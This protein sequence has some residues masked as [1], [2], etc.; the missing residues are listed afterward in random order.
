MEVII[1]QNPLLV[2]GYC[3]MN[4]VLT[5]FIIMSLWGSVLPRPTPYLRLVQVR[6]SSL[7]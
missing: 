3:L 7:G 1:F 6:V 5:K 2:R 4:G